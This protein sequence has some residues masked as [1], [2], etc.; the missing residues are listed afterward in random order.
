MNTTQRIAIIGA[1]PGGLL[2]AR[3]LQ[4][5][6]VDVTVYDVDTSVHA[7]DPGGTL[8]L[9]ADSGQIALED[10]GLLAAFTEISRPEGQAMA[11]LDQHGTV[12]SSF[13][14]DEDDN[15]APEVDR[16][17]LRALLAAHVQP[18]TVRW[19]HTLRTA[20]PLGGGRHRIEFATGVH[21]D[22]DMLIGADGAWSRVR[23]LVSDAVPQYSGVTFVDVRFD[24]VQQRH[25]GINTLVGDGMIFANNG[26]GQAII[27]QRNADNRVRGY[28]GL[29]TDVD[30]YERAGID[31]TDTA[32]IRRHLLA[33]FSGWAEHLLPLLTDSDGD[34]ANRPIFG[35]PAP[36]VWDHTPGVTLLGDAAHLMA[37]FGGHGVNLAMLDATELARAIAEEPTVDAA[38]TRYETVMLPRSGP[39]AA[40]ANEAIV[41][42]FA[43]SEDGPAAAPDPEVEHRAYQTAAAEYRRRRA[44]ATR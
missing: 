29:R 9:H 13:V 30:W 37:P 18:G 38:I 26:D 15:A 24:D 42:F 23:P 33:E 20:T 40:D 35:L 32:A 12:L 16:G 41:K 10:A 11:R 44:A 28:I 1:G 36:L 2:C 25:P 43:P 4:L 31:L 22:V 17:Q 27:G 34:Y 14:P 8:D 39:L 19:G 5:H 6:G 7:R 3:V 21:D